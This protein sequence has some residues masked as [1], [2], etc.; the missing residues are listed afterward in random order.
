MRVIRVE[1]NGVEECVCVEQDPI[2]GVWNKL[3]S[4]PHPSLPRASRRET[5]VYTLPAP[6]TWG[7]GGITLTKWGGGRPRDIKVY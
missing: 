1:T 3:G 6:P 4:N 7:S 2:S 5:K